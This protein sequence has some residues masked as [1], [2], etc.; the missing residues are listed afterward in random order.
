M[1]MLVWK[2]PR[3]LSPILKRL[4]GGAG[5]RSGKYKPSKASVMPEETEYQRKEKRKEEAL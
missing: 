3:I 1:K 4:F 2:A 5:G